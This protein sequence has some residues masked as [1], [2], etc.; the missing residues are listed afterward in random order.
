MKTHIVNFWV[1]RIDRAAYRAWAKDLAMTPEQ[2]RAF[3]SA[4]SRVRRAARELAAAKKEQIKIAQQFPTTQ[5][6]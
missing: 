1:Q 2:Q 5:I 4:S 3:A 6:R